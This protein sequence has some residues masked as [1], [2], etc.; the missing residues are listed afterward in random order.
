MMPIETTI[1]TTLGLL[2]QPEGAASAFPW[3]EW[4]RMRDSNPR[5]REPNPLSKRAP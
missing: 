4:R 1:E 2:R 3:W 5:G